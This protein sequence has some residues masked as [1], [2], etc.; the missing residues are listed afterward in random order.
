MI[1]F[2]RILHALSFKQTF[3]NLDKVNV[4]KLAKGLLNKHV[5][6]II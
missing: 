6:N 2:K 3:I 5:L 1:K 4:L